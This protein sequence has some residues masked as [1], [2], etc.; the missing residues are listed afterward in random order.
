MRPAVDVCVVLRVELLE[1]VENA[2]GLLGSSRIVEVYEL[3]PVDLSGE[4]G[5]E[6][7]EVVYVLGDEGLGRFV[8]HIE[9]HAVI[10]PGGWV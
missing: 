7:S 4:D 9:P 3:F 2:C 8:V 1:G 10:G 6:G 5:E